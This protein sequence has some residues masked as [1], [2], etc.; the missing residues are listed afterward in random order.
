MRMA[1]DPDLRERL[2]RAARERAVQHHTWA[3]NA[4]KVLDAYRALVGKASAPE[5]LI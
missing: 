1:S 3:H 4:R 2:G 5:D